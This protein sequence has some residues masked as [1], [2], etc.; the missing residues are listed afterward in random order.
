MPPPPTCSTT[1]R[2][3]RSPWST[4]RD[5]PCPTSNR[6]SC[7]PCSRSGVTASSARTDPRRLVVTFRRRQRREH[8]LT[9]AVSREK[10]CCPNKEVH[11]EQQRRRPWPFHR[12]GRTEHDRHGPRG[13]PVAG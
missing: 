11:H 10:D 2:T 6:N 1:T 4:T 13:R 9:S 12:D 3:P 7:A 8:S 5:T